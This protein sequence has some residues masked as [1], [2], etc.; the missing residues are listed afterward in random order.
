MIHMKTDDF[1]REPSSESV[2]TD[3][4]WNAQRYVLGE[5]SPEEMEA[6][7]EILATDQA[8]RELVAQSTRLVT[9]LVAAA[10][11]AAD[12]AGSR[13]GSP[14]PAR[15]RPAQPDEVTRGRSNR[16]VGWAITGL[17]AAVCCCV[18]V[19]VYLI[20]RTVGTGLQDIYTGELT[21]N[22]AGL[23]VSIWSQRLADLA[24]DAPTTEQ[25]AAERSDL[26]FPS[27]SEESRVASA[28]EG[29]PADSAAV[30][31]QMAVDDSDVPDWMVAA[32]EVGESHGRN[33]DGS[34]SLWEN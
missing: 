21:E 16:F 23:L 12:A 18:A 30:G 33:S 34:S 14:S 8:A 2:E 7:E 1:N 28:T 26:P 27:E 15:V 32:L 13:N 31:D 17:V 24:P 3:R 20:P 5:M 6:F 4:E 11:D 19:G 25:A 22:G 10:T 29:A 9:N